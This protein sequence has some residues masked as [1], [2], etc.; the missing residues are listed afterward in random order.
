LVDKVV[1]DFESGAHNSIHR[2]IKATAM[3]YCWPNC[4]LLVS[5][6]HVDDNDDEQ[7]FKSFKEG[8]DVDVTYDD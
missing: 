5:V 6:A 8:E 2:S 3:E 7:L 4:L 1:G